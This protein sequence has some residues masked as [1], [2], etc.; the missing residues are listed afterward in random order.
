MYD[1]GFWIS[2]T[3]ALVNESGKLDTVP[4]PPD[5]FDKDTG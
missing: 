5:A 3:L 2:D 1:L 4:P